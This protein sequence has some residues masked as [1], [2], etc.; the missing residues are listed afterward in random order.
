MSVSNSTKE[1]RILKIPI[2]REKSVFYYYKPFELIDIDKESNKNELI[3]V[4]A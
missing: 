2:N 1:Y 4:P 3:D